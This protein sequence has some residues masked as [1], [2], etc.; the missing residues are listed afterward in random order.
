MDEGYD[1]E[2][3][4]LICET[5]KCSTSCNSRRLGWGDEPFPSWRIKIIIACLRITPKDGGVTTFLTTLVI[6]K[7][8]INFMSFSGA[9]RLKAGHAVSMSSVFPSFHRC[10]LLFHFQTF[11][12]CA[13]LPAAARILGR[14]HPDDPRGRDHEWNTHLTFKVSKCDGPRPHGSTT[15]TWKI[16]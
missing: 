15:C 3:F 14:S 2:Q 12:G 7:D 1:G 13:Q 9:K 10:A 16:I 11:G 4:S 8:V 6:Y 5:V